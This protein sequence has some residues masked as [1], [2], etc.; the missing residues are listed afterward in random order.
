MLWVL[1]GVKAVG[2]GAGEELICLH[3]SCALG[4]KILTLSRLLALLVSFLLNT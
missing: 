4:L 1:P 3:S 2:V